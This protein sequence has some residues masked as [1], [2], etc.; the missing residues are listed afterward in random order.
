[1]LVIFLYIKYLCNFYSEFKN[2]NSN[3][4]FKKLKEKRKNQKISIYLQF[5]E[6]L[7]FDLNIL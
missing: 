2:P 6:K 5:L 4:K 7:N 3:L 1:M